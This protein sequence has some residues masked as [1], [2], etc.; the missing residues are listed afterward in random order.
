MTQQEAQKMAQKI[1]PEIMSQIFKL[2]VNPVYGSFNAPFNVFPSKPSPTPQEMESELFNAIWE[3]VKTWDIKIPK[4][5]DGYMSA[6]GSHVKIL[7]D[8]I[9]PTIRDTKIDNI[10]NTNNDG[11]SGQQ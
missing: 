7:M 5:D 1:S 11:T 4:Y 6:N 8:A 9:A 3:C 10:L 2:G